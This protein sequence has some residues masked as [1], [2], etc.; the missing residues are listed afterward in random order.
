MYIFSLILVHN[1]VIL[2][3][4]NLQGMSVYFTEDGEISDS[5]SNVPHGAITGVQ[6]GSQMT[7]DRIRQFIKDK[8][9]RP[10]VRQG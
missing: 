6:G 9:M 1:D 7:N 4:Q 5:S 8:C 2:T 10:L 3:R